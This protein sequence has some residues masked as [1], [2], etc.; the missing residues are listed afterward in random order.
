MDRRQ[1]KQSPVRDFVLYL[2][3]PALVCVAAAAWFA[4]RPWMTPV[5]Y[6]AG[7]F[8]PAPVA[9]SLAVGA[10]G[11]W[12]SSRVGLPSAPALN[13]GR[14]WTWLILVSVLLG[15][16]LTAASA[17]MDSALGLEKVLA[18]L[19]HQ[20]TINV[21]FPTSIA[22]YLAGGVLQE[23]LFRIGPIPIL[24]WIIGKLAF[25]D[26]AKPQVFWAVAIVLSLP[27]PV[28]APIMMFQA[29]PDLALIA[30]SV[31]LAGNLVWLLLY[32]RYGWTALLITR[33]VVELGWHVVW[34]LAHG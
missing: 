32:R 21:A 23:C 5:A 27:E 30:G 8:A 11:V 7:V 6:Q 28:M 10:L 34:P 26:P 29:H 24:T 31:Q 3:G 22:H 18:Q 33:C 12:L 2:C 25:R 13:D 17:W 19:I 14:R 9:T 1:L 4:V 20:P 15:V 16:V